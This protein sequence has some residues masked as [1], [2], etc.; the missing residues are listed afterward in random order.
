M[1]EVTSLNAWYGDSHALQ[2]IQLKVAER[3]RVAVL[4]RNGAGKSTLLKSIMNAGPRVAGHVSWAGSPL[5]RQPAYQRARMGLALVPEDR[6]IYAHLTVPE[7][8]KLAEQALPPGQVAIGQAELM[9][10]FPMLAPLQARLGNQLSGGQQQMVAVARGFAAR[11]KL[12][13]LDEPTEGLAP[14]IVEQLARSVAQMCAHYGIGLLLS[15]QNLW[16]ARRCTDYLYILDSGR[17]AFE[18]DWAL[19]DR[20]PDIKIKYLAV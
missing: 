15:E 10:H 20:Y 11:P 1:L 6:R 18:G 3:G 12:L 2:D 7:N 14:L 4:G 16:F 13:L 8:L 9:Q 19:F 5:A 17:V